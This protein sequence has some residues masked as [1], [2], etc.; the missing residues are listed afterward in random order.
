MVRVNEDCAMPSLRGKIVFLEAIH[1]GPGELPDVVSLR[2]DRGTM[3]T[4][5][6]NVDPV[7]LCPLCDT[8]NY[9]PE[10]DYICEHC[11]EH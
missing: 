1:F 5:A 4:S 9:I 7:Y 2:V 6:L 8:L 10:D 3:A 11:R